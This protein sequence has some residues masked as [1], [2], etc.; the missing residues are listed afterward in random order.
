MTLCLHILA[1]NRR[2][3]KYYIQSDSTRGNTHLIPRRIV[4]LTDQG[5]YQSG[6]GSAVYD[7]LVDAV[8]GRSGNTGS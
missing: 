1:R 5:Q 2:C 6:A 8:W 7:C 4:R 3:E